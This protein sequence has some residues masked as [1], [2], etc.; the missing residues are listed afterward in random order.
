MLELAQYYASIPKSQRR[1]TITFFTTSAHHSPSGEE[2]S[3]KWIHN[4]MQPMF[5][6]TALIVNCEHPSQVQTYLIQDSLV[7]SNAVSARRWFVGGS[8]TLKKIVHDS[9][10]EF[11]I[12]IY[13]RPEVRPGGELGVVFQDAPSVHIIDHAFYHTDMDT[14]AI[15]PEYG[16]EAAGRAFA[17]IIDEVNK[18]NLADLKAPKQPASG[19]AGNGNE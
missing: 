15:V 1:R 3:L 17:K 18:V 6:K 5:Q 19:P 14:P 11:G 9:F 4:N 13:S 8:D 12:A 7:A 2:A 10:Q 16:L